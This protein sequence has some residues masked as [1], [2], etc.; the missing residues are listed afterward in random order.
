LHFLAVEND[1]EGVKWLR[2][3]GADLDT[4]NAFGTP[5]L[6]EVA[7]L[8]YRDL[9]RWFIEH[10]ADARAVD[11]E[12]NDLVEYLRDHDCNEMAQWVQTHDA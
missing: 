7:Q 2:A 5:A 10:G 11:R 12:G 6:F 3:R 4:R 1:L 8:E 9:Y